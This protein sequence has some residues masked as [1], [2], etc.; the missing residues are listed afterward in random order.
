MEKLNYRILIVGV[1]GTGGLLANYLCKSLAGSDNVDIA[2]VDADVV[3]KKNLL[4]QPYTL[5]DIGESK[6][7][8]L[9]S[10]LTDVYGLHVR[11]FDKYIESDEDVEDCLYYGSPM[12]F[13]DYNVINIVCGCVDNHAARKCMHDYFVRKKSSRR[14]VEVPLLYV[15]SG[16]EFSYGEV[17]Y[18]VKAK[19]GKILSPDKLYYFPD[20]F[21][22]DDMTPRSQESCEVLNDSAPQHLATNMLAA[23]IMLSGILG[24]IQNG[25]MPSGMVTFDSGISGGGF[26]VKQVPYVPEPEKEDE[27]EKGGKKN[28][29]TRKTSKISA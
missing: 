25:T 1:G 8:A 7:S 17:V 12:H 18:A 11:T 27:Q 26:R 22:G 16:N 6:A 21:D 23:N 4:R 24:L 20:L 2:L 14:M 10:A 15:D 9:A 5:Q 19:N 3:E 13:Y 29:K 28:G